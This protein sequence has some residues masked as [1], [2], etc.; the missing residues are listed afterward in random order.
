MYFELYINVTEILFIVIHCKGLHLQTVHNTSEDR[1][2]FEIDSLWL[3]WR[4]DAHAPLGTLHPLSLLHLGENYIFVAIRANV[5]AWRI[6]YENS[7]T[8]LK[9]RSFY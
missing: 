2:V 5:I 1:R 7:C 4:L 6:V 8:K 3:V 9:P